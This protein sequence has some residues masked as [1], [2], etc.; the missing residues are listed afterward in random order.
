MFAIWVHDPSVCVVSTH[1]LE[2]SVGLSDSF[3]SL[4]S[5]V[6]YCV[7]SH[8]ACWIYSFQFFCVL[9]SFIFFFSLPYPFR[10]ASLPSFSPLLS[11]SLTSSSI[12]LLLLQIVVWGVEAVWSR[13]V[14]IQGCRPIKCDQAYPE[15]MR[16]RSCH[17]HFQ[18]TG[19]GYMHWYGACVDV[20]MCVCMFLCLYCL[21][22]F[23]CVVCFV[24]FC[25]Y[26]SLCSCD[27]MVLRYNDS[28]LSSPLTTRIHRHMSYCSQQL[29]HHDMIRVCIFTGVDSSC[30]DW[31]PN[32][33]HTG[34]TYKGVFVCVCM[35]LCEVL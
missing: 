20:W 5:C 30:G 4:L 23:V 33:V 6:F 18:N 3:P 34:P 24:C 10:I 26:I 16:A 25:D 35:C 1:L 29:Y 7:M 14:W 27:F 17:H 19:E 2:L 21:F 22:C 15:D 12:F 8:V 32:Q 11:P 28:G 13:C 31:H 9:L